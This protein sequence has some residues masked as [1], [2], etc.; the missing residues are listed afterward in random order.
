[1]GR[2]TPLTE[3]PLVDL[4]AIIDKQASVIKQLHRAFATE[5]ESWDLERQ[6]FVNR[7]YSLE[8]LLKNGEHH[9]Y[10]SALALEIFYR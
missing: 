5:R 6:R 4:Q 3:S 10:S 2:P 9:R 1:M 7:I 8:Q